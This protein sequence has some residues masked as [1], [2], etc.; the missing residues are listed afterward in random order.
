M[1]VSGHNGNNE[2]FIGMSA[3]IGLSFYD[4]YMNEIEIS[5]TQNPID[6]VIKRD[7]N[8]PEFSFQYVKATQIQLSSFL[9]S[10]A[11]NITATNAS[12]HIELMPSNLTIGYLLVIK[13]GYMPI[14][15]STYAD[16]SSFKIFCPSNSLIY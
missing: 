8:L 2:S 16:F 10:N 3:S 11:F 12:I 1:A 4:Q 7:P 9:L 5:N 15:N 13:F 6:I 14:I